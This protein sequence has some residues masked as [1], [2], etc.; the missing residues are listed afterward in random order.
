MERIPARPLVIGYGNP[1]RGDDAVGWR[2]AEAVREDPRAGG[3]DVLLRHQLTPELAADL[4][5][6]STVVLVDASEADP[7]GEV[8]VQRVD[9]V[10]GAAAWSHHVDPGSLLALARALY[11]AA[12]PLHVVAIG[13]ASTETRDELTEPVA[14]AVPWAVAAVLELLGGASR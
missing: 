9:D 3:A 8:R 13:I 7:P 1:L 5:A 2:V 10:P 4:A 6:A 11:G 14:A 12:P